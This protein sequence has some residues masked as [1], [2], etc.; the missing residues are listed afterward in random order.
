MRLKSRKAELKE[1]VKVSL[2]KIACFVIIVATIQNLFS[3]TKP[4]IF[5]IPKN[6]NIPNIPFRVF[7]F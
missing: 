1:Q 5:R 2:G 4:R 6:Q 7:K 3:N